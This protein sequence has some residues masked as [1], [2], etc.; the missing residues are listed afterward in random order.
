MLLAD[1]D[2]TRFLPT[3]YCAAGIRPPGGVLGT[4]LVDGMVAGIWHIERSRQQS[5][6]VIE[7]FAPLPEPV[8][9][10]LAAEGERLVRFAADE[11]NAPAVRFE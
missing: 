5:T 1:A 8:R 9:A 2:R 3:A 11:A 10:V 4:F 7:P 6:L